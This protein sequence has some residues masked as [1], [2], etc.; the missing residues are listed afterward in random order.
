MHKYWKQIAAGSLAVMLA[1]P[2]PIQAA[3]KKSIYV[4]D[5]VS[6]TAADLGLDISLKRKKKKCTQLVPAVIVDI[7]RVSYTSTDGI[8][9]TSWFPIYE[10]WYQGNRIQKRALTGTSNQDFYIGQKVK[11]Y[12]NPFN[13]NEFYCPEEKRGFLIGVFY[14]VGSLVFL[15]AIIFGIITTL[16]QVS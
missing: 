4:G 5:V 11:L 7:E 14:A 6:I 9:M 10:Y 12:L 2:V 8:G 16:L 15:L 1:T 3:I 13:P